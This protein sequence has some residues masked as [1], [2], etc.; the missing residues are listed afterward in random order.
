V[1]HLVVRRNNLVAD[2]ERA[3]LDGSNMQ[4]VAV[5]DLNI[6]DDKVGLAVDDDPTRVVLLSSRL[7]VKV[8][9]VKNDTDE[10]LGRHLRGRL[11]KVARVVDRLDLGVDVAQTCSAEGES[12]TER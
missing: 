8:G 10:R 6:L 5:E 2:R 1:T 7:G 3:L 9:L 4:H 12:A 11:V